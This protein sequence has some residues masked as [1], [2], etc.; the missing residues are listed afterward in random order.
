MTSSI[1]DMTVAEVRKYLNECRKKHV[2][3]T[4]KTPM[5]ITDVLSNDMTIQDF[6]LKFQQGHHQKRHNKGS[7]CKVEPDMPK[8]V[9]K[10]ADK[11]QKTSKNTQE[12]A[13][14]NLSNDD[15]EHVYF[16]KQTRESDQSSDECGEIDETT[17]TAKLAVSSKKRGRPKKSQTQKTSKHETPTLTRPTVQRNLMEF[18]CAEQ[19]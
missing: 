11:L 13:I 4:I 7:Q 10:P 16:S 2:S 8:E 15:Y 18:I 3:Q 14:Q 12:K 1:T 17:G 6:A 9:Y 5:Y 19:R